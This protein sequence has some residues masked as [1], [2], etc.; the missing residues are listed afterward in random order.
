M[1]IADDD[2]NRLRIAVA[3]I[4]R[5]LARQVPS[6]G[7]T[8]TQVSVLGTVS[9]LNSL[10]L[11]ELADIEG[12]NPTMVSRVVGKL[13]GMGF[14]R[15]YVDAAD[16][17]VAHVQITPTG[18]AQQEQIKQARTALFAGHVAALDAAVQQS[19]VD[20][21]PALEALADHLQTRPVAEPRRTPPRA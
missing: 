4:S 6:A 16:Q 3:R 2:I 18:A 8:Q 17:R 20:V 21:V 13:E 19:L 1:D 12:L 15:R 5:Q 11:G 9:R 7:M 14:I 10:S